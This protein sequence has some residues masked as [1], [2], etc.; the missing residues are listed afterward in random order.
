MIFGALNI[1]CREDQDTTEV[2]V[3]KNRY[4]HC[5]IRGTLLSIVNLLTTNLI[6]PNSEIISVL[7]AES[8]S[9]LSCLKV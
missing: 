4:F 6:L 3:K 2:Q 7:M 5:V 1:L 9:G 8:S